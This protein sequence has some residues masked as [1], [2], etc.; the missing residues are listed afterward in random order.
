MLDEPQP[1]VDSG[2]CGFIPEHMLAEM[3]S[4]GIKSKRVSAMQV[5][6]V[7]ARLGDLQ[8]NPMQEKKHFSHT[9]G[10]FHAQNWAKE[11]RRVGRWLGLDAILR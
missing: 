3:F 2:G 8:R 4:K 5:R 9:A 6:I 10:S 1:S 11:M 7:S